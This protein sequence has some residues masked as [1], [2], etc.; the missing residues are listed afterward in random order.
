MQSLLRNLIRAACAGGVILATS[1]DFAAADD[2]AS[3]ARYREEALPVLEGYC[4][5][6]HA[7]GINEGG[8]ALD[9][10]ASDASVLD[11]RDLWR[12]V[13]RNV[14]AGIMPPHGEDR[15]TEE[16]IT[17]LT[18][19]IKSDGFGIDLADPDPGRVTIRRLN[20]VEYRN[21]I[22]DLMGVDF[23]TEIEFP[24]DDTGFGFDNIGDVLSVSPLLLEKY[25]HA[26]DTIVAEAVPTV[27][28][29]PRE[30]AR[31]GSYFRDEDGKA[32]GDSLSFYEAVTVRHTENVRLDGTYRLIVV[33]EVD[34]EFDYDPGRCRVTFRVDGEERFQDEYVWAEGKKIH[35][36]FEEDWS[37][38]DHE[39]SFQLEPLVP[40]DKQEKRLNFEVH[41]VRIVGPM[42][43][44]HW[45]H[46]KNYKMFFQRDAPPAS[47]D[48]RRDYAREVLRTFATRAFRR[49]VDEA[50]LDR[51]VSIAEAGYLPPEATFEQ[52]IALA[53]EA[54]LSSPR[55]L[56][57][58]EETEP[59]AEGERF[60]LVD[61]F[62]LASRLSYFFWS[63]MPDDELFELAGRGELRN[64]L[65]AQVGRLLA[66][67]RSE[68]L[69]RNFVGQWLQARDVEH[70]SID[71]L[72]ALGLREE[73]DELRRDFFRRFRRRGDRNAG[74]DEDAARTRARF[75][76]LRE[77]SDVLTPDLREAMRQETEMLFEHI[78]REDRSILELIDSDYTFLN[79]VLARH[80]GI[81]DVEGEEMRRVDLPDDHHRGGVLTQG[82]F[83]L[84]TSNPTRTSPVKR[85]VFVLDNILGMAPPPPPANVPEL[86][87]SEKVLR[88]KEPTLRELLEA[89][90]EQPLCSSCHS[91][92]DP[93]GLALEN[94]NALGQWR[95]MENGKPIDPAGSLITGESFDTVKE[96]KEVLRTDRRLDF[97]RCLTERLLTYAMGR[98]LEYYDEHT[99][100]Q[101]V[102]ELDR[103]GGR[104][105]ALLAGIVHSAPFQRQRTPAQTQEN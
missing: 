90:R 81:D 89:H 12:R 69:V 4:Y 76:E 58:L 37:A 42:E 94:Y 62:A 80:Y 56:F 9:A 98:G 91:R 50:T 82:T 79:E 30:A 92:F 25:L 38:G 100:D 77:L 28:K 6:C 1:A 49:P 15:P 41:A 102:A 67:P 26:A 75:Q 66:D 65:D 83:L 40:A 34:G 47:P 22:R 54:V 27:A 11:S 33:A 7:Y 72:A 53:I 31:R 63:T 104:F 51:L 45:G 2:S 18:G 43:K 71:S 70:V 93:L 87:E 95:D 68:A 74:N 88:D 46:K 101:I 64:N 103:N 16:E 17:A 3:L 78:V 73:Y 5:G 60:L 23:D 59:L 55:F 13:L 61:E 84:V 85:G 44:E 39:L 97:Y 21:T 20:R 52:G 24:P 99:V 86:E 57:R 36:E 32:Q 35:Y 29:A 8:V 96:M 14:R 19:W 10:F 48:D 105:S